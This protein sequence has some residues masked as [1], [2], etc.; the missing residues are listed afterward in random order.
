MYLVVSNKQLP[1]LEAPFLLGNG[2]ET[3]DGILIA[4]FLRSL[5]NLSPQQWIRLDP[6]R[7]DSPAR[8]SARDA[9]ADPGS[10][11]RNPPGV[12]G[13]PLQRLLFDC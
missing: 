12:S 6:N 11:H 5:A 7:V 8:P 4:P 1:R 10:L 2:S 9:S 13:S 3:Q